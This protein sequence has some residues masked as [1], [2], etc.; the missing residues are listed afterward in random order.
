[1]EVASAVSPGAVVGTNTVST[2]TNTIVSGVSV[3]VT[4]TVTLDTRE[5]D[6][7]PVELPDPANELA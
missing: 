3:G 4:I 7:M 6:P 5:A 2:E 1:M